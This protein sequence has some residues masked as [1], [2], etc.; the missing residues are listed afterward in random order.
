MLNEVCDIEVSDY[1]FKILTRLSDSHQL[2]NIMP[3]RKASPRDINNKANAP[4]PN[5]SVYVI[6]LRPAKKWSRGN[7]FVIAVRPALRGVMFFAY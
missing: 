5:K 4:S 7:D 1:S 3:S 6:A 2:L